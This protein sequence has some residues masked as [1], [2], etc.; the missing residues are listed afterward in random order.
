MQTHSE[1]TF[2]SLYLQLVA[3]ARAQQLDLTLAAFDQ[4]ALSELE[5]ALDILQA[6][7]EAWV[8]VL[9]SKCIETRGE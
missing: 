3:Y 8:E 2:D 7:P 4:P 6:L 9:C 5:S 1:L